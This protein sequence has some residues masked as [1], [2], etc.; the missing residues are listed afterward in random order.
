MS[1]CGSTVVSQMLSAL[2]CN[3]VL[4]EPGPLDQIMRAAAWQPDTPDDRI[5]ALMRG[6]VAAFSRRRSAPE[7]DLFIKLDAWHVLL[8]PLFRRAFP[9]VPWVFI[10]R[11]PLEVLSSVVRTRP[12]PLFPNWIPPS[13]LAHAPAEPAAPDLDEYGVCVLASY[14]CAAIAH[15]RDGGLLVAYDELPDAACTKIL[16]HFGLHYGEAD[17]AAMRAAGLHD[18]KRPEL[19][20]RPDSAEK[21]KEAS[22]ELRRLSETQLSP[23][24]AQLEALRLAVR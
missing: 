10:Y 23:L 2:S 5:V 17:L 8:F 11:E 18:P 21:R 9:D 1:R 14:L 12:M 22:E 6:M 15:H 3:V 16:D 4:S 7:R 20:F 13:L 24:H 19:R